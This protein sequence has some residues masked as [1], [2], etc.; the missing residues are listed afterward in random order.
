L[1]Q[2]GLLDQEETQKAENYFLKSLSQNPELLSALGN[3]AMIYTETDR[4]DGAVELTRQMLEINPNN[5][6]AHYSL[7]YIYRY[8]GM[9]N[10]AVQEMEKAVNLDPKNSG[11]RSILLTYTTAG[12]YEKVVNTFKNFKESAFTLSRLGDAFYLQGNKEQALKTYDRVLEMEPDGLSALYA[13]GNKAFIEGNIEAG[14]DAAHKF[15]QANLID[16]EAWYYF[17]GI[18]SLLGDR[19]GC[20]RALKRAVD[21]GY[22]NYPYMLTDFSFDSVRDFPEFQ[23]VL[24]LAKSK[25]EAFKRRFFPESSVATK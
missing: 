6:E 5:A 22:F 1:A 11:F 12:E 13:T 20:V 7:G 10:E 15:E 14:L 8:A 4:T 9:N 17:A 23:R 3:L 19:D 24:E 21:G 16:A 25:H 2:Y 18:Y